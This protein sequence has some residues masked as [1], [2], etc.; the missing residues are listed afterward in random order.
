MAKV[1]ALK[2]L[3]K[4]FFD[5]NYRFIINTNVLH[6]YDSMPDEKY[7]KKV[8]AA[9][10]NKEL[11]LQKPE[12]FNEKLQWIKLYDR[13]PEYT[14]M[15]DKNVVKNYVAGIIGEQYII[16]TLGVWDDPEDIDF[17]SLP[18]QFV[19]KC[20][21]NSGLGMCIC[22]D[23]SKLNVEQVKKELRKGLEQDYYLTGREWPY[24]N[25]PR[26]IIAEQY[27]SNGKEGLVDYK[28]HNFHGV[29]KLILV[30]KDR[31]EESGLTEDF[32]SVDWEV[33]P[34]KRPGIQTSKAPMEKPK[35]LDEILSLSKKLSE[36]IP[37]L[38][39]DFYI[40][41]QQVYFSELTFFP[42]SGF[43]EF[44]P[45]EWDFILGSWIQI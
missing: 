20:N 1:D 41:G 44:E 33:L 2:K 25:V 5:R 31:F 17:D 24:K 19:L 38:R 6:K 8:Y 28:V 15:V 43:K 23:K 35:Q 16:P 18:E 4:Y 42:A 22:T 26:K 14:T 30:C 12:R 27:M 32:Y 29:P 34:V 40:I 21:H 13:K 11:N 37:F 39:T 45:D 10:M 36:N 7:L 3:V 9:N